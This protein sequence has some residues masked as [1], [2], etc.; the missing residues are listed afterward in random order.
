VTDV[1]AAPALLRIGAAA[2]SAGVTT[3]T[4]RY[5]EQRGL[6]Q[7]SAYTEGGERRYTAEDVAR[8][9]RV[10]ELADLLGADLDEIRRAL[11]A[12]D[13]LAAIRAEYL[14]PGQSRRRQLELL[15]EAESVNR[16]LQDSVGA[17]MARLRA[18][19]AELESRA[20]RYAEVRAELQAGK[21]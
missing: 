15:D 5:Y 20:A 2:A 1:G 19:Q 4:L 7:P 21:R 16:H 8:L 13:R 6:L 11:D 9:V 12:E 10:R 17:R 14:R 3:R 18:V